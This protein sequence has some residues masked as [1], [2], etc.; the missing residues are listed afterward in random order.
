MTVAVKLS[1]EQILNYKI[2]ANIAIKNVDAECKF[3]FN[4]EAFINPTMK[5][6]EDAIKNLFKER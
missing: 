6:Y 1:D 4:A 3:S 5:D 2:D